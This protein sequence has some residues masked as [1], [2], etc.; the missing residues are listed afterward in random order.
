MKRKYPGNKA[1]AETGVAS[2]V[3]AKPHHRCG[4]NTA[5]AK[6][7]ARITGRLDSGILTG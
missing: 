6:G 1:P 3:D 5:E 4:P 2:V 7:T